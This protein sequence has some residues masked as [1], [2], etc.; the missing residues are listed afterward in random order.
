MLNLMPN[1]IKLVINF[2]GTSDKKRDTHPAMA[3]VKMS[4]PHYF[5]SELTT[6]F[7]E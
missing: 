1:I 2:Y 5:K 6:H 3:L 4:D 7:Y